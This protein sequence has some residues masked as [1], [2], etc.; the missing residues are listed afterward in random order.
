MV[1]IA[2]SNWWMF[3]LRGALAI[4]FGVVALALPGA[5]LLGLVALFAAFAL[6][7][8]ATSIVGALQNRRRDDHWWLALLLGLVSAGAGVIA[9][10][11]PALT[12]LVLVL[13][14]GANA[15]ATGVLDIALAIRLRRAIRGEWVLL[16]AGLVSVV[17]GVLVFVFPGAG[18]LA[19]VWWISVY[20]VASGILLLVAAWRLRRPQERWRGGVGQPTL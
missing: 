16:L 10:V 13:L 8:G 19:L 3:A 9:I 12:A 20:A 5:T 15:I 4:A 2:S 1:A 7:G 11:S 14:M 18:A 17:F 6:L